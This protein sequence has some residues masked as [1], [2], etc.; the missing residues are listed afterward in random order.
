MPVQPGADHISE[1]YEW[2]TGG[3][4]VENWSTLVT[5]HRLS[6]LTPDSPLSAEAYAQN[7]VN[8]N[9]QQG[10]I[11]I[12]T[13]IINAPD[14]VEMGIDIENPP[15]L[16]IYLFPSQDAEVPSE[17]NF[18]KIENAGDGKV[19]ILIYA[20]RLAIGSQEEFDAVLASP[21]FLDRRN[22]LIMSRFPYYT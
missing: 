6:P 8:L 18:Q 12:E 7:V 20:E 4:S 19:N 1:S 3:E 14:A 13:S 10:A 9:Q 21:E 16:L 22:S 5:S 15:F 11:I 17:I 2:V